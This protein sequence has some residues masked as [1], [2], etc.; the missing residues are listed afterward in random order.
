MC[1]KLYN[2]PKARKENREMTRVRAW[3]SQDN[4]I[5]LIVGIFR[6]RQW[7]PGIK[8]YANKHKDKIKHPR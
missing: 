7:L 4:T 3:R 6:N 8:Q 1:G 2:E 5:L